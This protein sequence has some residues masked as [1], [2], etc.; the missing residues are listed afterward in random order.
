M[1]GQTLL[2]VMYDELLRMDLP[3][4]VCGIG[5]ADDFAL[6]AAGILETILMNVVNTAVQRVANWIK[7]KQINLASHKTEAPHNKE[8]N[9]PNRGNNNKAKTSK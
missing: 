9:H 8:E 4:G 3:E 6:V 7:S 5:F 1:L 2:N